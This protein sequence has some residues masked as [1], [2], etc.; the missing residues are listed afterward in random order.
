MKTLIAASNK[1]ERERERERGENM[2]PFQR[3]HSAQSF[4]LSS[5]GR[6]REEAAYRGSA[7]VKGDY[8]HLRSFG[9]FCKEGSGR[10]SSLTQGHETGFDPARALFVERFSF[11]KMFL[12]S[13]YCHGRPDAYMS[14]Y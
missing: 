11:G 3:F 1:R 7:R 6:R 5:A 14:D 13:Y 9:D 2:G 10:S 4:L 8:A 12:Q